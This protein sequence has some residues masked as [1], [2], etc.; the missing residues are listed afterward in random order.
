[1]AQEVSQRQR[2]N[3]VMYLHKWGFDG[4]GMLEYLRATRLRDKCSSSENLTQGEC[5]CQPCMHA[6][7]TSAIQLRS[8]DIASWRGCR[9]GGA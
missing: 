6:P 8:Q 2:L 7:I 3:T 9:G 4:D 5:I 1:M